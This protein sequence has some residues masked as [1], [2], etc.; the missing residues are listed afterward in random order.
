MIVRLERAWLKKA[1]RNGTAA[2]LRQR[3]RGLLRLVR[4]PPRR[5]L[6]LAAAHRRLLGAAGAA[7]AGQRRGA[8]AGV[9]APQLDVRE[10]LRGVTQQRAQPVLHAAQLAAPVQLQRRRAQRLVAARQGLVGVCAHGGGG[11]GGA[12]VAAPGRRALLAGS[13]GVSRR[14]WEEQAAGG[15][16]AGR[17]VPG[18]GRRGG[19]G[20]AGVVVRVEGGGEGGGAAGGHLERVLSHV[21]G[22]GRGL[23]RRAHAPGPAKTEGRADGS[24]FVWDLHLLGHPGGTGAQLPGVSNVS[25]RKG[26]RAKDCM[27]WNG[28]ER[29]RRGT[30]AADLEREREREREKEREPA[31]TAPRGWR[32]P[33]APRRRAAG[34]PLAA[35]RPRRR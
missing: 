13:G 9:R 26:T 4:P 33:A 27:G 15:G 29:T 1:A 11:G 10:Q 30:Q 35:P 14:S 6:L 7:A 16:R 3:Q 31:L 2:H 19:S 8:R 24:V 20:G 21:Q 18:G 25:Q 5:R 17:G 34:G 28:G 22:A 23:P 12:A 32:R